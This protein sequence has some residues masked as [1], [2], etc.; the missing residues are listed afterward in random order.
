V[1]TKKPAT[2]KSQTYFAQVP[3]ELARRIAKIEASATASQP[4]S[5]NLTI[6]RTPSATTRRQGLPIAVSRPN[7]RAGR[8]R[9]ATGG[10]RTSKNKA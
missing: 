3:L 4:V 2:Q 6:E 7:R 8:M 5:A 10:G 9:A 1:Q